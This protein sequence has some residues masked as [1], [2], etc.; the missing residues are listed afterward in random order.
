MAATTFLA[1]GGFIGYGFLRQSAVN[2]SVDL[3]RCRTQAAQA[4]STIS[5]LHALATRGPKET[6][7]VT[8]EVLQTIEVIQTVQVAGDRER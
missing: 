6:V 1:I 7:E 5:E 2:C 3:D 4:Q 8:V